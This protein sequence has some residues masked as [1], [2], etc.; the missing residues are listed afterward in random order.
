MKGRKH[1]AAGGMEHGSKEWEQDLADHPQ[2]YNQSKVEDEAEATHA[3]KGGR[4]KRKR[5]GHVHH[6][7]GAHLKHAKHVGMVHGEKHAAHA[8]RKPRKAGGRAKGGKGSDMNPLSSAHAGQHPK[9]HQ[10]VEID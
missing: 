4:M 8:G 5:G 1:H 6:E 10:D 2:R 3:R 7:S 9:A